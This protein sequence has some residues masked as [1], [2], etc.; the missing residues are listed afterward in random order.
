MPVAYRVLDSQRREFQAGQ[1]RARRSDVDAQSAIG[2]KPL[3]PVE[4]ERQLVEVLLIAIGAVTGLPQDTAGETAFEVGTVGEVDRPAKGDSAVSRLDVVG[5]K[6]GKLCG[7]R[8]LQASRTWR[9]EMFHHREV[10]LERLEDDQQ[11]RAQEHRQRG[12]LVDPAIEEVAMSIAVVSKVQQQLAEP[13]MV[14][15]QNRDQRELGIEP[16]ACDS[17][18]QPEPEA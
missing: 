8:V 6:F 12:N 2:A 5:A 4:T 17:I 16:A 3:R 9:E 10:I 1:R 18:T 15:Y 7:E 14:R 13:H 11:H